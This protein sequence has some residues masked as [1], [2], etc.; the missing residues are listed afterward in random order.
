MTFAN[1]TWPWILGGIALL[2]AGL[3]ALQFLRVRYRDVTVV[4]TMLWQ[5]VLQQAPV[6]T[7]R[8]R[9]EHPWAYLLILTICALLWTAL[10]GPTVSP[11]ADDRFHVLILD[12]SAR[13]SAQGATAQGVNQSRYATAVEE[14]TQRVRKLPAERRQ[15]LWSGASARTLLMPGEDVA[16]LA[17]RLQGLAPEAAPSQMESLLSQ[18]AAERSSVAGRES[19]AATDVTIFGDAAVSAEVL[20]SLPKTFTVRRAHAVEPVGRN[21]GITAL[22]LSESRW[23]K[24][25]VYLEALSSDATPV[26]A[27]E[28]SLDL[29]GQPVPTN[30]LTASGAGWLIRDL[31]AQGAL[32]SVKLK[33]HD[34]LPLDDSASIRLP[35]RPVLRVQLSASLD[36]S[37]RTLLQ[38]DPAVLLTDADPMVVVRRAGESLGGAVPALEFISAKNQ[39]AAFQLTYPNTVDDEADLISAVNGIGLNQI[40]AMALADA[41]QK[42]IEVAFVEGRQWR[43]SVW[44]E[45]LTDEFD[46]TRSRAFPL[47]V[48]QSVRWLA[49]VAPGYP[50]VRAGRELVTDSAEGTPAM[51]LGAPYVPMKAGELAWHTNGKPLAVSLLDSAT[52]RA[53][54]D[55][56]LEVSTELA[57]RGT[58]SNLLITSLLL[59]ALLALAGE[60]YGHLQGRVP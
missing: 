49:G 31:P 9:F 58:S 40:D 37:L 45:L 18:I 3:Y 48:A 6:R 47:L 24:V 22:G 1:F 39:S 28:F 51:W 26:A 34:A 7:F 32:F 50:Y 16:L 19:G 30:R 17:K 52:T 55:D 53:G 15:V 46:F 12:G 14:L 20:S 60:W 25:T 35:A 42:P 10:A 43:I 27:S 57:E 56:S 5:Q 38:A 21:V 41:A 59:L 54:R 4:S 11:R 36:N 2:A 8:R 44:Q 23:G 13:M 33:A 29:D